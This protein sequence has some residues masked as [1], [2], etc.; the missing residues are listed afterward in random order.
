MKKMYCGYLTNFSQFNYKFPKTTIRKSNF[1]ISFTRLS[2]WENFLQSSEEE[3]ESP[4][5]FKSELELKLILLA[6]K[7]HTY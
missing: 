6:M 2:V 5:L 3:I 4:A 7:I 1:R